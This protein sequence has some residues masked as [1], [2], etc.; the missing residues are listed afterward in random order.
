MTHKRKAERAGS[1]G[2]ATV[3]L[4]SLLVVAAVA[5]QPS[6][7][8]QPGNDSRS[9]VREAA[10][11]LDKLED[12]HLAVLIQLHRSTTSGQRLHRGDSFAAAGCCTTSL[13]WL[14]CGSQ[15]CR[16]SLTAVSVAVDL[17]RRLVATWPRS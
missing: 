10:L 3:V 6:W 17:A 13:A 8:R 4:S 12:Q 9:Q 7:S 16:A 14:C 2:A 15:T 5:V 1:A 11:V